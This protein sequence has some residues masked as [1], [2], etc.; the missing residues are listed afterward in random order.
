MKKV[1]LSVLGI[2]VFGLSGVAQKHIAQPL[3]NSK[4][5]LI[6]HTVKKETQVS[7][8]GIIIWQN[9]FSNPAEWTA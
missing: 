8:K 3:T 5:S 7:S 1:Y 2:T 4:N 6:E 9:D